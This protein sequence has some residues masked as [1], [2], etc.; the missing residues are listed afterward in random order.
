MPILPSTNESCFF[1]VISPV[2]SQAYLPASAN[3]DTRATN[4]ASVGTKVAANVT[5]DA[6][7]V[8][9]YKRVYLSLISFTLFLCSLKR[10]AMPR[11]TS[12]VTLSMS[13]IAHLFSSEVKEERVLRKFLFFFFFFL[14]FFVFL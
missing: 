13:S 6:T 5:H 14:S 9:L 1:S 3:G 7:S 8:F 2:L 4:G 10:D 12:D 11:Q